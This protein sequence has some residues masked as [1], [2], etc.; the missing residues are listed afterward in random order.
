MKNFLVWIGLFLVLAPHVQCQEVVFANYGGLYFCPESKDLIYIEWDNSPDQH[1]AN[2]VYWSATGQKPRRMEIATQYTMTKRDIQN[3]EYFIQLWE[4]VRPN[5]QYQCLF[6]ANYQT[7]RHSMVMNLEGANRK[8]EFLLVG[9]EENGYMDEGDLQHESMMMT[10]SNLKFYVFDKNTKEYNYEAPVSVGL[11]EDPTILQIMLGTEEANTTYL[12]TFNNSF[13]ML[14]GVG[15]VDR[16]RNAYRFRFEIFNNTIPL[17][18]MH[19]FGSDGTY[20]YSFAE[21]YGDFVGENTF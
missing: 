21:S 18:V 20:Y 6:K 16:S 5:A 7:G 11:A 9:D 12:A 4:E 19:V 14:A 10:L 2:A 3:D 17:L 13:E 15:T 1:N 8:Y